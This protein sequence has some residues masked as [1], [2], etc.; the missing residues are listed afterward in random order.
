M[1]CSGMLIDSWSH[2]Y[3]S[4]YIGSKGYHKQYSRYF[5]AQNPSKQWCMLITS[6]RSWKI[7]GINYWNSITLTINSGSMHYGTIFMFISIPKPLNRRLQ[8]AIKK[9]IR[10][11]GRPFKKPIRN[12]WN[13]PRSKIEKS[14]LYSLSKANSPRNGTKWRKNWSST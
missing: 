2:K 9:K 6:D 13:K 7:S 10:S 11:K 5:S 4:S 3:P 14:T 8:Q 12:T 1:A